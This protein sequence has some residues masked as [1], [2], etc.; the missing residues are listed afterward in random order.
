M[1]GQEETVDTGRGPAGVTVTMPGGA[2][3]A[4]RVA[5]PIALLV[6]GHGAGG[7]V[8]APDLVA[9]H[10]A[11]VAAGVAV[12]LVTQPYRVAGR[13]APAPAAHLD[14][15]WRTVVD[16]LVERLPGLPLIVG[17]RS[18]GARVACRTAAAVGAVG[19]VALA[20]PLHPPGKPARSRAAELITGLPTL[21]VNGSS[22]PFGVPD[23]APGVEI[24]VL[25]GERHDL[26]KAPDTVGRA[27]VTWLRA[28]GWAGGGDRA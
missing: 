5:A 4:G 20:F 1:Q 19:I 18:S 8:D 23:A 25:E 17:G 7:S 26:R 15:A 11:A 21:V 12:A 22:D 16:V 13:R 28:R 14:E 3:G 6:L 10:D 2:T 9:V 27:V 24:V